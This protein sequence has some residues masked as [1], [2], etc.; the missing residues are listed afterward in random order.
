MQQSSQRQVFRHRN[1]PTNR[2]FATVSLSRLITN[3]FKVLMR[4]D[5]TQRRWQ[6]RC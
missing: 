6:G 5:I 1:T 2:V 4:G 3:E